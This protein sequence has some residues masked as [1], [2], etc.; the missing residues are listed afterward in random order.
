MGCYGI[1]ISR[2]MGVI[3]EHFADER[4]MVWPVNIAPARAHLI[5]IGDGSLAT[6]QADQL[7]SILTDAGISVL[8]DNRSMRPGEQFADADLIGIP[9]RI[10]ISDKTASGDTYEYKARTEAASKQLTKAQLLRI[11]ST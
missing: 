4:G 8:Y 1:G 7:Y 10:V 11:V 2:L 6:E 3:V 9:H 5:R